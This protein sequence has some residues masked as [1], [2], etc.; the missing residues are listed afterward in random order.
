[1][2]EDVVEVLRRVVE[3]DQIV[4]VYLR[5][6]AGAVLEFHETFVEMGNFDTVDAI[7]ALRDIE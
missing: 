5:D 3:L 6:V 1:M 4:F 2:G 7:R